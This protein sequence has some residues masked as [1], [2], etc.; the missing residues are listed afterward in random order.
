MP[1]LPDLKE[2]GSP[3]TLELSGEACRLVAGEG[4]QR[5]ELPLVAKVADMAHSWIYEHGQGNGDSE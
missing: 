2:K 3:V 4:E 5:E 1:R